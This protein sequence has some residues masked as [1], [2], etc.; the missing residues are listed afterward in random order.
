MNRDL[1]L[2]HGTDK[3][4]VKVLSAT[5]KDQHFLYEIALMTAIPRNPWVVDFIGYT[6]EPARSIIMKYYQADLKSW[7]QVK[8][9][10]LPPKII[11]KIAWDVANGINK[12]HAAGVLHLD[13]KPG[14]LYSNYL[15]VYQVM[16]SRK[17]LV[18]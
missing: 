17:Y 1:K 6:F 10:K 16:R 14:K 4:A 9:L 5:E 18:G 2:K 15:C 12:I 7:L 13:L 8:D 3:I 11:Y